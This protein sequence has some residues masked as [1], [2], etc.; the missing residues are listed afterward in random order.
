M[1]TRMEREDGLTLVEMLVVMVVSATLATVALGFNA[2]ARVAASDAAAK[3]N[4]DVA[5]PAVNGYALDNNGYS[6]MTAARL[7]ASYSKGI[8]VTVDSASAATYC[9]SSTVEGSTWYKAGPSDPLT[10]SPCS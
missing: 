6:G 10:T 8:A 4:L 5:V 3:S 9:I 1:R 2:S 7:R